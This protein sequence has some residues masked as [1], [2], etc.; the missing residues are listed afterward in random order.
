MRA[1][2]TL[3]LSALIVLARA[4]GVDPL[5]ESEVPAPLRSWIPWVLHDADERAWPYLNNADG[6]KQCV[7]PDACGSSWVRTEDDSVFVSKP[8]ARRDCPCRVMRNSDR[9]TSKSTA[10][11]RLSLR[12]KVCQA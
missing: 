8:S 1:S 12:T 11:Q 7:W 4:A 2:R 9:R 6:A 3:I 10:R 5:P